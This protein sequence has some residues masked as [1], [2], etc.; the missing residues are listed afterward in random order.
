MT[1]TLAFF[2]IMV[3]TAVCWLLRQQLAAKPWLDDGMLE[4]GK[5][6][7]TLALP[8]AKVGL[9]VFLAVISALFA[10]LIGAY[11]MRMGFSDWR[12]LRVPKLLWLS[13]GALIFCSV[14]LQAAQAAVHRRDLLRTRVL[15]L[16]GAAFGTAFVAGQV[17]AWVQ[18]KSVQETISLNPSNSFF[19]LLTGLHGLHVLGGLIALGVTAD[20]AWRATYAERAR[21]SVEMSATYWHFLL[22][23]WL[24]LFGMLSGGAD[25]L[26]KI[27]SQLI[28]YKG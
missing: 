10:L 16:I 3:G 28:S 6:S 8:A 12:P 23:V 20:I 14:A 2:V 15:L 5:R 18:L 1:V 11:L 24:V 21:L 7:G 25:D 4:T 13:T 27:C 9:L 19:Y 17:N 22:I 26:G